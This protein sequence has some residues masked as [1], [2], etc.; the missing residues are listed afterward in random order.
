MDTILKKHIATLILALIIPVGLLIAGVLLL[1]QVDTRIGRIAD[2]KE[3]IAS[4]QKNKKA[5]T[6][7]V[8]KIQLLEKRVTSLEASV[9]TTKSV[10]ALLSS[11]ESLAKTA[12]VA[13]EITSVQNPIENEVQTLSIEC[14]IVGSRTQVLSFLN[15]LQ[16]QAFAV[17]IS[18]LFVFSE[19]G[20]SSVPVVTGVLSVGKTKAPAPVVKEKQW[21]GVA[22]ITIVSF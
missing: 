7:E 10:P 2:I 1:K 5:F 19:E 6:D 15:T 8:A 16:H 18:K 22:T 21:H 4:Y 3:R 14:S 17:H 20:Q 13:F 11:L 9:I 12:G